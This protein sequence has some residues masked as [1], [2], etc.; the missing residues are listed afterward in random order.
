[1]L[2]PVRTVFPLFMGAFRK[3]AGQRFI[4]FTVSVLRPHVINTSTG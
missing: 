1:M 2:P 3:S 4:T